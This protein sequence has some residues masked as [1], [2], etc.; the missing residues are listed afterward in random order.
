M[1]IGTATTTQVA[2]PAT[3]AP[4]ATNAVSSDFETF[5]KMLTVQMKNQDPLEPVKSEDFAVQLATFSS[6]EQ[7]VLTNNLLESLAGQMNVMGMAQ[8]AGWVGME[9]LAPVAGQFD[10]TPITLSPDPRQTADTAILIVHDANGNEV[11]RAQI[12]V[13]GDSLEWT[14][15]LDDGSTL[16]PGVYKFSVE[17]HAEGALIA[18]DPVDVYARIVEARNEGGQTVL[19]TEGG[20]SVVASSV[21]GLREPDP[22]I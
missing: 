11:Q 18:T 19:I 7:Q 5:L 4:A 2:Q 13:S 8:L 20:G 14:G 1:D 3:A 17:S 6:V 21:S 12:P 16:P 22:A 10:G 15:I 9:A